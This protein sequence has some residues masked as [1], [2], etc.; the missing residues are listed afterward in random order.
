MTKS[1]QRANLPAH[2]DLR[3]CGGPSDIR[4]DSHTID[5]LYPF[6]LLVDSQLRVVGAGRTLRRLLPELAAS[7]LLNEAFIVLRPRSVVDF[8]SLCAA[9]NKLLQLASRS[10]DKLELKGEIVRLPDP[11]LAFLVLTLVFSSSTLVD[12]LGLTST[13]F[14]ISDASLDFLFLVETQAALLNDAESLAASLRSAKNEAERANHTKGLFLANMSHEIRTPMNGVVGMID[15]LLDEPLN[16]QQ[17]DFARMAKQS[18]ELL[19]S[20]IDEVL[21]YSKLEAGQI[22][23]ERV[24]FDFIETLDQ[25]IAIMRPQAEAKGLTIAIEPRDHQPLYI[26]GDPVRLRQVLFNLVGNA[27]KFT[28]EGGVEVTFSYPKVESACLDFRIEVRDS[29][30]GI[31]PEDKDHLFGRFTQ[32]DGS[33]TRRFGGTGLGLAIC[34]E[35]V[36]LMGGTIGADCN[37]DRGSTFWIRI[38]FEKAEQKDIAHQAQS[39]TRALYPRQQLKILVAD[40]SMINRVLIQALLEKEGHL[41]TMANDG[42][43]AVEAARHAHFD[44]VLMDVHMPV[45]DGFEATR[46]IRALPGTIATVPIIALTASAMKGDRENCLSQGMDDYVSK[47]IDRDKLFAALWGHGGGARMEHDGDAPKKPEPENDQLDVFMSRLVNFQAER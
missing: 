38:G 6:H 46:A 3:S 24:A 36:N 4:I 2:Q 12:D 45:M 21:D 25:V 17:R 9:E 43:E 40:D 44:R 35:L 42:G 29:G 31:N 37:S 32:A 26:F 20:I 5:R 1:V 15:L 11:E 27:I 19:L 28:E 34:R 33:T 16:E 22:K 13:D 7:P 8:A 39:L 14:A 41:V 10:N 47:P 18:G 23:I 30:I